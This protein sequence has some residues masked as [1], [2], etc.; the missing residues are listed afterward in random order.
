MKCLIDSNVLIRAH[1]P[2]G[3]IGYAAVGYLRY[4][5]RT[6]TGVLGVPA[7]TEFIKYGV[8]EQGFSYD[9]MTAQARRLA[10][11]F[12][13]LPHT[14]EVVDMALRLR[15]EHSISFDDAQV[16]ALASING[17]GQVITEGLGNGRKREKVSYLDVVRMSDSKSLVNDY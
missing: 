2:F 7:L 8:A 5:A 3:P 17:V 9:T 10:T 6:G 11:I 12:P 16:L 4:L 15:S 13:V 14:F 1:A